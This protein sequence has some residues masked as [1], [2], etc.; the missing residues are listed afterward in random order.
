MTEIEDL[1]ARIDELTA[2]NRALEAELRIARGEV[3]TVLNN[4]EVARMKAEA[5]REKYREWME[6]PRVEAWERELA[7]AKKSADFWQREH[8]ELERCIVDAV[9]LLRGRGKYTVAEVD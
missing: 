7:L 9:T 8:S 4:T 3:R 2:A 6:Q 1:Q 5:E